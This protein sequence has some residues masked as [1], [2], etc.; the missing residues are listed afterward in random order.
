VYRKYP[1]AAELGVGVDVALFDSNEVQVTRHAFV[2]CGGFFKVGH[3]TQRRC[4]T[5][6]V[7]VWSM[8]ILIVALL[9]GAAPAPQEEAE[10]VVRELYAYV[11]TSRP[12]GIP[13][14]AEWQTIGSLFSARVVSAFDAARQCEADYFRQHRGDDGKP[15]F[16]WLEAGLFSGRNEQAIPREFSIVSS[17]RESTGGWRVVVKLTYHEVAETYCCKPPDPDASYSWHVAVIVK[18]EEGRAVVD[19]ILHRSEETDDSNWQLSGSFDGCSG[20]RWV[21]DAGRQ[22]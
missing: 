5:D 19:E 12:L 1:K 10:R 3:A 14:E 16:G 9:I 8:M 4:S 2:E 20:V 17:E 7:A 15:E 13:P 18:I 11:V 21:G 6:A 22:P